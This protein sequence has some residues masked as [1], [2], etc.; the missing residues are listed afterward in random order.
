MSRQSFKHLRHQ[1]LS[2]NDDFMHNSGLFFIVPFFA[3]RKAL[4][5]LANDPIMSE[6]HYSCLDPLNVKICAL[7]QIL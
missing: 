7:F 2:I 4:V 6:D 5:P 1:N 3:A